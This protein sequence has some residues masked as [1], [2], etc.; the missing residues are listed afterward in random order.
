MSKNEKDLMVLAVV[1]G[2]INYHRFFAL[3]FL[4]KKSL[5]IIMKQKILVIAQN[6]KFLETMDDICYSIGY[7]SYF[8]RFF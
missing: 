7:E 5:R 1:N 3:V 8:K 4:V 6:E 2:I